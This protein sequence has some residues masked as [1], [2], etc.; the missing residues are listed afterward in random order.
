MQELPFRCC[1]A[2]IKFCRKNPIL[3]RMVTAKY[4]IMSWETHEEIVS[5][6]IDLNLWKNFTVK[7]GQGPEDY[8]WPAV[9]ME[10]WN[11]QYRKKHNC[12]F[13]SKL[14]IRREAYL[15]RMGQE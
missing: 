4:P 14:N 1:V 6:W 5:F 9:L 11:N 2:L 8:A 15:Q 12:Y 7:G 10:E 13:T 3:V